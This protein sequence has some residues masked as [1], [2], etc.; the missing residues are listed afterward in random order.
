MATG[1]DAVAA[2][3]AI[4]TGN[5]LANT[6]DTEV[7]KTRDYIAQRTSAVTPIEKGGTGQ[8]TAAAARGALGINLAAPGSVETSKIPSYDSTGRLVTNTPST[9]GE[10]AN[11]AYVDSFWNAPTLYVNSLVIQQQLFV[12]ASTPVVSGYVAAYINSDGRLGKS[13]SARRFKKE[14]HDHDYTVDDLL[15][16]QVRSYRLKAAVFGEGWE[17]A[18]VEVGVIAEE[19][20]DAGLSEFVHFDANG[21]PET[22][23]YER[24]ALVAIGALQEL[25]GTV[26]TIT[27]RLEALEAGR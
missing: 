25:A 10:V 8:T 15:G 13:P 14:I 16:I 11:K 17:D 24:L 2:G 27:A 23:H 26:A 3:M 4:L 12:P 7:N 19:L 6:I 18:P 9:A 1:D 21:E 22:V 5:E 20:I